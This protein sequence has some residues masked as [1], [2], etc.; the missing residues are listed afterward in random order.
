MELTQLRY[1]LRAA[2]LENFTRAAEELHVTQPAL[3]RA[4]G[5][6]EEELGQPLFER[7]ARRVVLTDAGRLLQTRAARVVALVDDTCEELADDGETGTLR[8]GAI[9]TI[10]PYVLPSV[11]GTFAERKPN[12]SLVVVE[13]VTENL[14]KQTSDGEVDVAIV[15]LPVTTRHLEVEPLFEEELFLVLPPAHPLASL[16]RISIEDVEPFPIVLLGPGHCLSDA[17]RSLCRDRAFQPIGVGR[18]TQLAT[19][20][21]MVALGHGVSLIPAMARVVDESERREY[22]SFCTP[23]PTRRIAMVWNPYR[24]QSRLLEDFKTLLRTL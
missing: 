23:P 24:F 20:L 12:A 18:T 15:A 14:L 7:Q 6:L 1:F 17:V 22:R 21:E 3:S 8:V 11:L 13:D 5:R 19:V 4:V 10:A 9:P 2:E 16:G